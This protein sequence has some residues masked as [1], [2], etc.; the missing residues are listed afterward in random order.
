MTKV[1]NRGR[2]KH[3]A[4][5]STEHGAGGRQDKAMS[6]DMQAEHSPMQMPLDTEPMSHK[7]Q[8]KFGH[9]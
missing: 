3:K 8:K 7:K 9:N 4:M 1:K 6:M 2:G 5:S